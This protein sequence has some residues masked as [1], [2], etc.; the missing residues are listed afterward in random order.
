MLQTPNINSG[1]S[2]DAAV[3]NQLSVQMKKSNQYVSTKR[4]KR[5]RNLTEQHC[6][7]TVCSTETAHGARASQKDLNQGSQLGSGTADFPMRLAAHHAALADSRAQ[8]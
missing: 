2:V 4:T 5:R 3:G 6:P 7:T 1:I 8:T